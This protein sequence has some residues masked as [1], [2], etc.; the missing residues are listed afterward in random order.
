MT[1]NVVG[2]MQNVAYDSSWTLALPGGLLVLSAVLLAYR[3]VTEEKS[4]VPLNGFLANIL[5]QMMPLIVLKMKIWSC[6]DR[7]SLVPIVLCKT[8]LMHVALSSC[9][10]CSSIMLNSGESDKL[11]IMMDIL[12]LLGALALLK[13]Q[14]EFSMSPLDWI[15]H[16]DVRNL[17]I[18]AIGGA[19]ASHAFFV[20]MQPSWMGDLTRQQSQEMY[21]PWILFTAANYIDIVAFMPVVWRIY[22][23]EE[24]EESS[25][26]AVCVGAQ[27]QTRAFFMYVIAFYMWDDVIDPI[28]TI[29]NEPLAM[30]AHAAH[31]VLLLDFAGFFSFQVSQANT[32]IVKDQGELS[33]LL[34]R[35]DDDH[36]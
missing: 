19:F 7:V 23:A 28:M 14:F 8:L 3:N 18:L 26:T 13:Y 33:G 34:A 36:C 6:S 15:M 30:M 16:Q 17:I 22:Q 5:L 35:E 21:F 32:S 4:D 1:D 27:S 24:H 10:L 31:F 12:G 20:V 2:K 9:R 11:P 25:G 29:M